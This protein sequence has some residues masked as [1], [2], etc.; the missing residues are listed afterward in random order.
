MA[1]RPMITSRAAGKCD[2]ARNRWAFA[3]A[4]SS[5]MSPG[6]GAVDSHAM[7]PGNVTQMTAD[8]RALIVQWFREAGG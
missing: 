2:A 7:P 5:R 8:E 4:T 1:Q 3:D 6:L